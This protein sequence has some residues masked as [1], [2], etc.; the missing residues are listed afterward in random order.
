MLVE[1]E[2]KTVKYIL[3]YNQEVNWF[4]QNQVPLWIVRW[5]TYIDIIQYTLQRGILYNT[6]SQNCCF[7][8]NN[9]I[10]LIHSTIR[11]E[12]ILASLLFNFLKY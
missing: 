6:S 12:P 1:M 3:T 4:A 8:S 7:L 11:A 9:I 2:Y 5:E 10:I